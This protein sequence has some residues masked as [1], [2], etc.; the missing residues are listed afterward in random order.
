M[1]ALG[2]VVGILIVLIG[3]LLLAPRF[4]G[5][6]PAPAMSDGGEPAAQAVSS[7]PPAPDRSVDLPDTPDQKIR[8][9]VLRQRLPFFQFLRTNYAKEISS[10]GVTDALDTLDLVVTD[11]DPQAVQNLIARAV[12]PTAARYGIHRVRIYI[13]NPPNSLQPLTLVAE[14]TYDGAGRWNTFLK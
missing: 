3:F 14:S 2:A 9:E 7:Q 8:D 4:R 11:P 13:A 12:S 1:K 6:P 5:A 10:F